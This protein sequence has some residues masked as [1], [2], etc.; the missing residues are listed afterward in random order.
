MD[1]RRCE[2]TAQ[3]WVELGVQCLGIGVLVSTLIYQSWWGMLSICVSAPLL[4]RRDRKIWI[5]RKKEQLKQEFREVMEIV[6][7]GLHAGYSLENAFLSARTTAEREYPL[8]SKE[9]TLLA[10]GLSCRKRIEVL[11]LEF[12]RRSGVPEILEFEGLIETA[13]VYGGNIPQLIRQMTENF[14]QTE[15]LEAEIQTVLAAKRLEGRIMLAVPFAIL[16]YFQMLN[17]SYIQVFYHTIA[18][19]CCMTICMLIIAACAAWIE[20]IVRIEV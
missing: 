4:W 10:N 8:M 9:L 12:G 15:Q 7:G 19:R 13:K 2:M 1:Y 6:S 18:G 20:K 5:R 14:A 3:C 17:P 11:L 16:L